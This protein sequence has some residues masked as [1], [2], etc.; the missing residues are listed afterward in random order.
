M[1]ALASERSKRK[2][3]AQEV[4]DRAGFG[5]ESFVRR[6][7][8]AGANPTLRSIQRYAKAVGVELTVSVG[9]TKVLTF[10]NHAGGVGKTSCV[11]D[12]GYVLA[13]MGFRVLL[14]DAD[15]QANLT[16][17]LGVRRKIHERDT[18]FPAVIGEAETLALPSPIRVHNLDLI[19]S[20]L[21][22]AKIDLML[23]G[24]IMGQTRLRNAVRQ[25]HGYDFVL[26]DPPPS[27]GQLSSLAVIAADRVV[28]PVPTN[29][30]GLEG[31]ETVISMVRTFRPA[32]PDLAISFFILTQV[33]ART[34]HDREIQAT[35]R[36]SLPEI[37]PVSSP[38]YSRPAPY[39]DAALEGRPLPLFA[40][41]SKSDEEIRTVTSELL[42]ALG[43]A[44][45]VGT[46]RVAAGV[47]G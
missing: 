6:L 18:I 26:I 27:L 5:G 1:R 36:S 9:S 25:L 11:R 7:E 13:D 21:S 16:S 17:W 31:I 42:E 4:A 45:K 35:M 33:D 30:K 15:P 38:L 14:I 29:S 20:N 10:F 34:K 41:Q 23:P 39:K 8:A 2:L 43:V 28:V 22:V 40:P 12:T 46:P 3:S 37:A 19:P 24:V 47:E 32:A 44:I